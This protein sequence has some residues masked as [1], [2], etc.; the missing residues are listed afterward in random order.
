MNTQKQQML[1][2]LN[3]TSDR[4]AYYADFASVFVMHLLNLV[5]HFMSL[6]RAI[7]TGNQ[8]VPDDTVLLKEGD[9]INVGNVELKV[10]HTPDI[11]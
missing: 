2:V 4:N 6:M 1:K 10:I 11:P 8:N 3:N 9:V 5:R 7:R